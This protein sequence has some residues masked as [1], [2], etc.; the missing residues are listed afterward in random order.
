MDP[1]AINSIKAVLRIA[2]D[3]TVSGRSTTGVGVYARELLAALRV[4]ESIDLCEW[5][6]PLAP[7]GRSVDRMVNGLRLAA[8]Y[9]AGLGHRFERKSID[10]Y[11]ATTSLGPLRLRRPVVMTIHDSSG[12]TMPIHGGIA[13]RL[14]R[15][16]FG[17]AA[18]RSADAI[19]VPTRVSGEAVSIAYGVPMDRIRV[20]PLGVAAAFRQVTPTAVQTIRA[21]YRLNF[22]YVLHVGAEPPRKNLSRLVEAFAGLG[23][24][25]RDVRLVLAGP[26]ALRDRHADAL[27]ER[28]RLGLRVCRLG[29]VPRD[30]LPALYAGAACLASVSLCEGF[31]LPI[32]EAMAAGTP[33][34]TSDCSAMPEVA[35]DAAVF[36][37]PWSV[38]AIAAGLNLV[39][40]DASLADDLRRRGRARSLVFDWSVTADLTE[41][42]YRE[43]AGCR[44]PH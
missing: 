10:L 27:V 39:L 31:G 33:V 32:V 23:P 44:P 26:S 30:D 40:G 2:F 5:R 37:D 20:A 14:F 17:V 28:L 21:R 25:L 11:H 7:S 1:P 38:D 8:W 13:D 35:G 16:V 34:V 18:A 15:Q 41:R 4:R 29:I 3:T 24:S 19:L 43:V 42:V 36:V 12:L 9:G 22:P 6:R